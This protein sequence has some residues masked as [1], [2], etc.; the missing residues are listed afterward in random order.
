MSLINF[1]WM[2]TTLYSYICVYNYY[3]LCV[4]IQTLIENLIGDSM[5]DSYLCVRFF[6]NKMLQIHS[7]LEVYSY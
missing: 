2:I 3:F 4:C 1:W 6:S 7:I 5:S